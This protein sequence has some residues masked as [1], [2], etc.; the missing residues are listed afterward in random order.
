MRVCR[1]RVVRLALLALAAGMMAC[2]GQASAGEWTWHPHVWHRWNED[3]GT[4]SQ[5]LPESAALPNPRLTPGVADPRVTQAN[6]HQTICVRGYSR[7]VR[8]P[9]AYTEPLK[10]QQVAEYGYA[11]TRLSDYEEDHELSLE[12]GGSPTDPRNLWPEPHDVQGGWGSYAKDRLENRLHKLVCRG[13]LSLSQAQQ[14]ITSNWIDAYKR[15]VGPSPN[16]TPQRWMRSEG[17]RG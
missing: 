15:Y 9:E 4:Q 1:N 7:S 2:A 14:A 6:I 3:A 16:N 8:P 17:R 11:D 5:A 10:R 13:R 12:L